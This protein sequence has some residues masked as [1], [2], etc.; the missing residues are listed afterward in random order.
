MT[1]KELLSI[2][3]LN[4]CGIEATIRDNGKFVDEYHISPMA[5]EDRCSRYDHHKGEEVPR[6]H[7]IQKPIN[8]SFQVDYRNLNMLFQYFS[9]CFYRTICF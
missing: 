4:I 8:L 7:C 9:S 6:W 5:Q 2:C 1:L 3:P